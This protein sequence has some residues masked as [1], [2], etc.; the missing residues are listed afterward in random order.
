MIQNPKVIPYP[1][2]DTRTPD[3]IDNGSD[4]GKNDNAM[5]RLDP[6]DNQQTSQQESPTEL[7]TVV[8]ITIQEEF[9]GTFVTMPASKHIFSRWNFHYGTRNSWCHCNCFVYLPAINSFPSTL[10]NGIS[11]MCAPVNR[12]HCSTYLIPLYMAIRSHRTLC[13]HF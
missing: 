7:T 1:T 11:L 6:E 10:W 8:S 12:A 13:D 5:T 3:I 9:Y 4:N 2:T